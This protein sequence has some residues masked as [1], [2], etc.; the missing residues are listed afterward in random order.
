MQIQQR[1]AISKGDFALGRPPFLK[2][3]ALIVALEPL[4]QAFWAACS[5]LSVIY[6]LVSTSVEN[7]AATNCF[8]SVY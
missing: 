7:A 2:K 3:N 8:V 1:C 4:R 6:E 5:P